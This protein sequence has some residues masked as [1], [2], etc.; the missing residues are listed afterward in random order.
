VLFSQI[1]EI[2]FHG[3]GYDYTSVY[4]MPIWLRRFTFRKLEEYFKKQEEEYNKVQNKQSFQK[5][6]IPTTVPSYNAKA[7][8]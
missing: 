7:R 6:K 8:K 4:N 3:K 2:V 1:H 5:P